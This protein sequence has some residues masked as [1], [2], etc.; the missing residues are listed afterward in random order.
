MSISFVKLVVCR[1]ITC[2]ELTQ[3]CKYN[4]KYSPDGKT[5]DVHYQCFGS[6]GNIDFVRILL[7][8]RTNYF[9]DLFHFHS[10][11]VLLDEMKIEDVSDEGFNGFNSF[12]FLSDFTRR[13]NSFLDDI[14]KSFQ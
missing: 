3:T 11:T 1:G 12:G 8:I 7:S 9:R 14:L 4:S 13:M 5:A 6:D 10:D 2:P